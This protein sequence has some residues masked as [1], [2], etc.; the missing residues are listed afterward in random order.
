MSECCQPVTYN[1]QGL[2][3]QTDSLNSSQA[4]LISQPVSDCSLDLSLE[5]MVPKMFLAMSNGLHP[6]LVTEMFQNFKSLKQL[7]QLMTNI[8][9]HGV[10]ADQV[11]TSIVMAK[12]FNSHKYYTMAM[13]DSMDVLLRSHAR[14][15]IGLLVTLLSDV[16]EILGSG[17][18]SLTPLL[19]DTLVK[20]VSP[21]V[22]K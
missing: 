12:Q 14:L 9:S 2:V 11:E 7:V 6:S 15:D 20:Q 19:V 5:D 16:Y 1:S 21:T 22:D 10:K 13:V 4:N 8:F 18:D 17:R 3:R